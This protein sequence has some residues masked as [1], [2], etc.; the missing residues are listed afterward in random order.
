MLRVLFIC[1]NL[2]LALFLL[3]R[4]TVSDP[5]RRAVRLARLLDGLAFLLT[6]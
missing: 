1:R 4:G 2:Q 3:R 5:A 6:P